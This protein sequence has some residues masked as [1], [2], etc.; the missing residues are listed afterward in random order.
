MSEVTSDSALADVIKLVTEYSGHDAATLTAETSFVDHL[1]YDSLD[2]VEIVME[3]EDHHRITITD[4]EAEAI[5]T[6]G[7]AA[8]VLTEKRGS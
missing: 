1:D 6:L 8:R 7:D 2:H 5:K 4:E 3:I